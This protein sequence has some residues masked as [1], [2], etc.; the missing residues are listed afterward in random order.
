VVASPD[1][2]TK[3]L[4]HE[5]AENIGLLAL[6]GLLLLIP[7]LYLA[8][9]RG[10]KPINAFTD[11]VATRAVD[12]LAP[13]KTI[14]PTELT[15]LKNR[16]NSLF[17]QVE[18]TIA[19]EQ[20][21]TADA[22]HELRTPLAATRLQVE[23]AQ[24]SI[25]PDIRD[26]ALTRATSAVDR[27]THVVSQLLLLARLEHG[28]SIEHHPINLVELAQEALTEADL[29]IDDAHLKVEGQPKLI[30]QSLLWALVLR[31][32]I[33][34]AKRYGG[35]EVDVFI[36]IAKNHLTVTDTGRG[37]SDEQKA[38]LGERFYRPAGQIAS[39]AGLGWS[40][41][42]RIAQLHNTEVHLFDVKPQGFGVT[43]NFRN[44]STDR[45]S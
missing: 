45:L 37:I 35:D 17:T 38:R 41:I 14:V 7:V 1:S 27:A 43:F 3:E 40:I 28:T 12:N 20:R 15:P 30:G 23:L 29:P 34:N 6:S 2:S 11:E 26:K 42:Q 16:L 13:I 25:R 19:R 39:G 5:M 21:F 10:L 36:T 4:S 32:L 18:Q 8:L 22:A 9:R 33:D 44:N 24:S 31:N